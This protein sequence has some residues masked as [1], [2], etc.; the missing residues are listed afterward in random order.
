M[1]PSN[2]QDPSLP[3]QPRQTPLEPELPV[4]EASPAPVEPYVSEAQP[5]EMLQESQPLAQ[6]QELPTQEVLANEAVD[7]IPD[8]PTAQQ[9][10]EPAYEAST[11]PTVL[12]EPISWQA[13]ESVHQSKNASWYT[14]LI[15]VAVLLILIAVFLL[16]L[17]SFA[18]LIVVMAGSLIFLSIH[19]PRQMQYQLDNSGLLVNDKQY[20]FGD[21]RS[22][23]VIQDGS[24]EYLRI[25]HVKKFMPPIDVYF[26]PE[27]GEEIV[28][29]LGEYIPLKMKTPD[30][31][32]RITK[33]LR[34]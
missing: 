28:G 25:I 5:S 24:F 7:P 4:A 12:H 27:R 15:I 26:P 33:R 16:K 11:N 13:S 20:S 1:D 32:D 17:W 18:V 19:P 21:F 22:F 8:E 3:N 34:L 31:I 9:L 29:I 14:G 6:P 30:V 2:N 23:S 10:D